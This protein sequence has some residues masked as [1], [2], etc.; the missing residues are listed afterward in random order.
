MNVRRILPV[1]VAAVLSAVT[2]TAVADEAVKTAHPPYKPGRQIDD[3]SVKTSRPPYK[4]GRQAEEET[5]AT[6][7]ETPTTKE[8]T[9]TVESARPPY[10]PGRKTD[11]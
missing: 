2:F 8:G 6:N 1:V 4:P 10:K 5:S 7:D 3:D 11:D 9:P